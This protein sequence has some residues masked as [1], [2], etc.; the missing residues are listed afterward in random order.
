ML[1]QCHRTFLQFTF[2]IVNPDIGVVRICIT[3]ERFIQPDTRL[4]LT[5]SV[6]GFHINM[7]SKHQ[8]LRRIQ[9][10]IERIGIG[11]GGSVTTAEIIAIIGTVARIFLIYRT[12]R[13][14]PGDRIIYS[15]MYDYSLPRR[16]RCDI[17]FVYL[18]FNSKISHCNY[19]HECLAVS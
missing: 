17:L 3:D 14:F 18:T 5:L 11:L 13:S 15:G 12:H 7:L 9:F 19:G 8:P 10:D 2:S 6:I 1:S 16:Y 4:F